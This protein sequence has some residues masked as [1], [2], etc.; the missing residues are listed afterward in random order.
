MKMKVIFSSETSSD[1][2]RTTQHYITEQLQEHQISHKITFSRETG[3]V[4]LYVYRIFRNILRP[5][6]IQIPPEKMT[7]CS[8]SH[9]F[10]LILKDGMKCV[11]KI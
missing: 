5:F 10:Q 8:F 11:P 6:I 9:N 3:I 4:F 1:F 7:S 2:Q